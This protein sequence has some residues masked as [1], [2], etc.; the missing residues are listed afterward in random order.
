[1][2]KF[3]IPKKLADE[4]KKAA[5]EGVFR[6]DEMY[7]MSSAET[8]ALFEKYTDKP[9][10]Q[11]INA[12]FERAM[13]SKQTQAMK[14]WVEK[15]FKPEKSKASKND[16]FNKIDKFK[17][18][19]VKK[20]SGEFM[21]DLVG[22]KLGANVTPEEYAKLKEF[23]DKIEK[24]S[25]DVDRFRSPKIEY[26]DELRKA[27]DYIDSLTPASNLTVVTNNVIPGNYLFQSASGI[28]NIIANNLRT[29]DR[30]ITSALA[31]TV[32]A[33]FVGKT[34]PT[35]LPRNGKIIKEYINSNMKR[36]WRTGFD[37]SRASDL[38]GAQKI[39]GERFSHSQG[40]GV[41]R[42]YGRFVDKWVMSRGQGTYDTFVATG[43]RALH[44]D[45]LARKYA[46][47]QGFKG[48]ELARK[49][50][51]ILE[52]SLSLD[53]Q[54]E[55]AQ[56]I[57][58]E[59]IE[60]AKIVTFQND[61]TLGKA[62]IGLRNVIN[63][64]WPE[65]SLGKMQAPF[66][67][68][69]ASALQWQIESGTG[70]G[71]IKST[72]EAADVV[73]DYVR[74]K[75]FNRKKFKRVIHDAASPTLAFGIA[76]LLLQNAI[77]PDQMEGDYDPEYKVRA[78]R[79]AR[80]APANSI[81]IDIPGIGPKAINRDILGPIGVQ[82]SVLQG[83]KDKEGAGFEATGI[84]YFKSLA[85]ALQATPAF[86]EVR[87]FWEYLDSVGGDTS[88][89]SED[90]MM[91]AGKFLIDYT[92]NAAVPA[93]VKQ[94]AKIV[95]PIQREV[96]RNKPWENTMRSLPFISTY[97]PAKESFTG[98]KL[99]NEDW[100]SIMIFGS[101]VRTPTQSVIADE[102]ARLDK[103]GFGP[104]IMRF[105][106][107]SGRMKELK[108]QISEEHYKEVT[109]YFR[110]FFAEKVG[111]LMEKDIYKN[112]PADVKKAMV[113]KLQSD[114]YEKTL[115]EFGYKPAKKEHSDAF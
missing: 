114:V 79:E 16:I 44:S 87:N 81:I 31:E 30:T 5:A 112:K 46:K 88:L 42:K 48:K 25:E 73:R 19:G 106:R 94:G 9:T 108:G 86:T 39:L 51:E 58:L 109:K 110:S 92:T 14:M 47:E 24:L 67:K 97:L 105:D 76:Y 54:S 98:E 38:E 78:L 20:P 28:F 40:K 26:Y 104:S 113:E 68:T 72:V 65:A 32:D 13:N 66:V 95:D 17:E 21:E 35:I 69:P 11:K 29:I 71:W 4:L 6:I 85:G 80:N 56:E 93:F 10:A 103:L 101:R 84:E 115:R 50:E 111:E 36:Q 96:D 22:E 91:V 34:T 55:I 15:T 37:L 83:M 23:G 90:M 27:Q 7:D 59:A 1:M 52:D 33:T 100:A 57:A 62:A 70:L 12:S 82:M 77:D 53:P 3:C 63:N 18:S 45:K 49:A 60:E 89:S 75:K 43:V 41:I 107:P 8:R 102:Y 99:K 74:D 64:I 61:T 2:A